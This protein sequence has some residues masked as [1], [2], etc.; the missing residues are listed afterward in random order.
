MLSPV[1]LS[2]LKNMLIAFVA[3]FFVA[4]IA[5]ITTA[6]VNAVAEAVRVATWKEVRVILFFVL[7]VT[8]PVAIKHFDGPVWLMKCTGVALLALAQNF[9]LPVHPFLIP[10]VLP[11]TQP[12]SLVCHLRTFI[13]PF[14]VVI[15]ATIVLRCY[16]FMPGY[17]PIGDADLVASFAVVFAVFTVYLVLFGGLIRNGYSR[18]WANL[19]LIATLHLVAMNP[20]HPNPIVTIVSTLVYGL[21]PV[22]AVHIAAVAAAV[23]AAKLVERVRVAMVAQEK[24]D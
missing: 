1:L 14:M 8:A 21:H 7:T 15:W 9:K 10:P 20:F 23:I 5:T 24:K 16:G 17:P 4:I 11:Q 22:Y 13:V 2:T 6:I 3:M 19:A 18:Q 12:T